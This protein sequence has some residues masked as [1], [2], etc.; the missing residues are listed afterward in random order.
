M[1]PMRR[2]RWLA[3]VA[4]TLVVLGVGLASLFS[5]A[6]G[7]GQSTAEGCPL[8][9]APPR[10]VVS[11]NTAP[12]LKTPSLSGNTTVVP[13]AVGMAGR[14]SRFNQPAVAVIAA[15]GLKA[16]LFTEAVGG[17]GA[18]W[19]VISQSP[20]AGSTVPI[21]SPVLLTM[22]FGCQSVAPGA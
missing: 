20:V 8:G 1:V 16:K 14:A 3:V 18:W 11:T 5:T 17:G 15:A 22:R 7:K 4:V 9:T 12:W 13:N 21:G 2:F 10:S 6:D 19:S